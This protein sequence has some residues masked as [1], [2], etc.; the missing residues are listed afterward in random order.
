VDV[1]A[2]S[3]LAVSGVL[4]GL[5]GEE[6][7]AL[8]MPCTILSEGF[9]WSFQFSPMVQIVRCRTAHLPLLIFSEWG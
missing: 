5:D 8:S 4:C 9:K 7:E 6:A 2:Q 1:W 3:P